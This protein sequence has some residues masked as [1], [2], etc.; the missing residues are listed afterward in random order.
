MFSFIW[1]YINWSALSLNWVP[2]LAHHVMCIRAVAGGKVVLNKFRA[3]SVP[4][5]INK[6]KIYLFN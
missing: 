3:G 2:S 5:L 4:N 6:N 1:D